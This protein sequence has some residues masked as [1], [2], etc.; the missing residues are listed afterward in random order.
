MATFS[1][2]SLYAILATSLALL[3]VLLCALPLSCAFGYK[4]LL[5]GILIGALLSK[6]K[7]NDEHHYFYPMHY[8]MPV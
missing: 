7:G 1:A 6:G 2:K 4:K 8:S 5:K 3:L